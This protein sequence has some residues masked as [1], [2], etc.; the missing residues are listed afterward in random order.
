MWIF[1]NFPTLPAEVLSPRQKQIIER[2]CAEQ[3]YLARPQVNR[4]E[5]APILGT[6]ESRPAASLEQLPPRRPSTREESV[7][8]FV[9]GG[10]NRS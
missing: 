7:A 2:L 5:D 8:P 9:A 1:R 4:F 10:N 6:F 3:K